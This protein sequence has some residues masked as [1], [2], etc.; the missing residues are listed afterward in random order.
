MKLLAVNRCA[1]VAL[2]ILTAVAART[3]VAQRVST[4]QCKGT[5]QAASSAAYLHVRDS[6]EPQRLIIEVGP[7]DIP[8]HTSAPHRSDLTYQLG[9]SPITGWIHGFTV[10]LVDSDGRAVPRRLLHH[11]VI[12]RPMSRELFLSV[13]QR[14]LGIGQETRELHVP[15]W[16][17]GAALHAGEPLL[18]NTMLDNPTR[19]SYRGVRVQLVMRYSRRRPAFNVSPFSIDAM[20]PLGEKVFDVPPGPSIHAWEGSPAIPVRILAVGGHLHRYAR[21]V[22]LSDLTTGKVIWRA[23][24]KTDATGA[25]ARMPVRLLPLG[26]RGTLTPTHRYRLAA[27]YHNPTGRTIQHGGMA[28]IAGLA[29]PAAGL[30]WPAADSADPLYREDLHRLLR[31]R[32]TLELEGE[33]HG[34]R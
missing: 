19:T 7:V 16:F 20:F 13:T 18:V 21:W 3:G 6:V 31:S 26:L 4:E 24:P 12:A 33:G 22:E 29:I 23:R 34:M 17:A 2:L 25:I 15:P 11:I 32:C 1:T 5:T 27:L 10:R 9:S 8:A 14:F 28:K 30:Q